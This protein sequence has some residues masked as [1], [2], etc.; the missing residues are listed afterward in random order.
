MARPRK[1]G[2]DYFPF[3]VDFFNDEKIVAVAGEFG[4]KGEIAIIKLLCA[5]Y[6]NGYF[7]EWNEMLQMKLLHQLPGISSELITQ[8]VSRLVRWG[9]FDKGLFDSARV[10]TSKGIQKRYFAVAKRRNIESGDL[11]YV[12][13]GCMQK[14]PA[15]GV[16][17]YNNSAE[18][19]LTYAKT[20]KIKES[21][22]KDPPLPPM[23]ESAQD[24]QKRFIDEFLAP[25]N[26]GMLEQFCKNIGL[27]EK[28]PY[29]LLREHV[30]EVSNNL[31]LVGNFPYY[32]SDWR[33]SV[34]NLIRAK[35]QKLKYGTDSRRN[36]ANGGSKIC[37][38][39]GHGVLR[40][41]NTDA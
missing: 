16:S 4:I 27:D 38:A 5:I 41:P 31:L 26:F 25:A 28:A 36:Q 2:L 20:P 35:I 22:L 15:N 9:F 13:N 6:R 14:S 39:P 21:K 3:D 8:I 40:R 29:P 1:S 10:L 7:I 32:E 11:P 19:E 24:R 17:A 37:P 33:H 30:V 23:G 34:I 18:A 12:L